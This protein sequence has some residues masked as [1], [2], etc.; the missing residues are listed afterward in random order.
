M[1][2]SRNALRT[3]L[4][5]AALFAANGGRADDNCGGHSVS[6]GA[7]S[8]AVDRTVPAGD[9]RQILSGACDA[10][11]FCVRRDKD[12]DEQMTESSYVP[13]D[14]V[15]T[16]RVVGG[17][18]KYAQSAAAGW[19]KQALTD[20][21][22]LVFVWGGDCKATGKRTPEARMTAAELRSTFTN[23]VIAGL[24]TD[25]TAFESRY[26]ATGGL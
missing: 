26:G 13:G 14:D 5:C 3:A 12:G 21:E 6:I 2:A 10:D 19:Y 22:V 16:W 1:S 18:G 9:A 15:P 17:T 8:I 20:N 7:R 24:C 11:G 4:A 25:G 23:V